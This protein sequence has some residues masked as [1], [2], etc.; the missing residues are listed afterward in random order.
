L[1]SN[2]GAVHLRDADHKELYEMNRRLE[3]DASVVHLN[4][5][6]E[7]FQTQGG[8]RDFRGVRDAL[9]ATDSLTASPESHAIAVGKIPAKP[10]PRCK[11]RGRSHR[12][13]ATGLGF[14]KV[15][16]PTSFRKHPSV[17]T[18]ARAVRTGTIC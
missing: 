1:L 3:V 9:A 5:G 14:V 10:R 18:A 15:D 4:P 2:I 16:F 7:I 13:V 12:I 11:Q 8:D 17:T 6:Q